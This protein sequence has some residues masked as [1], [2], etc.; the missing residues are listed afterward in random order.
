MA[1][2]SPSGG[3][4]QPKARARRRAGLKKGA[5]IIADVSEAEIPE[6]L[7]ALKHRFLALD[8]E[9]A[10]FAKT[11]PGS[12]AIATGQA[13]LTDAQR[14]TWTAMQTELTELAV[15]IQRHPFLA[16]KAQLDRY[17]ADRAATKAAK[18]LT[19]KAP[20]DKALEDKALEDKALEDKAP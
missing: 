3:H 18:A 14:A 8:A 4:R 15:Q 2:A 19:D 1:A 17:A 5:D 10:Q 20:K 16:A 11:L 6:D 7:V 13:A 9:H 12:M